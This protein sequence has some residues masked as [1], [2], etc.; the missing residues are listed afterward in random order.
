MGGTQRGSRL[1]Q[2]GKLEGQQPGAGGEGQTPE[3]KFLSPGAQ[4]DHCF[5]KG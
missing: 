1:S 3:G 2:E 5:Y 4:G